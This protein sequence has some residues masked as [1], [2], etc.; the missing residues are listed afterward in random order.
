VTAARYLLLAAMLA[1]PAAA[2]G[3]YDS[4][5]LDDPAVGRCERSGRT[6]FVYQES[7]HIRGYFAP[8]NLAVYRQSLPAPFTMPER[9]MVRVSFLDFY[10]MA[11]GPTYREAE[12]SVLAMQ[13]AQP[14][15]LVLTL[16]VTDGP[17]CIGGRQALGLPKVMRKI[18]LGRGA[19]RYVG[20]LY[21]CGGAAPE[22]TLTVDL[23]ATGSDELVRRY[24]AYPQFGLLKGRVIRIG[25]SADALAEL[26]R[27]GDYQLRVGLARLELA[28]DRL[29]IGPALAAHWS[30]VRARYS[31]KP[32]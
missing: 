19:E 17:A 10:E 18:T 11:E 16:P 23:G 2:Q 4:V 7:A 31:I 25:G 32:Q 9:P 20:T 5:P 28:E 26:T 13:E 30:R 8:T 12:V 29:G 3:L 24:A 22:M 27:R 14:G 1:T 15:W 21:A 6:S